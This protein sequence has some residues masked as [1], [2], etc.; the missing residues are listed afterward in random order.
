VK[1]FLY[2]LLGAGLLLIAAVAWTEHNFISPGPL[3]QPVTI[4]FAPGTHFTAIVNM[5]AQQRVITHPALFKILVF[6]RGDSARFK[7][8]EYLFP[9]HISPS[10]VATLMASGKT[11]IHHLT[12]PEGLMTS[13]ILNIVKHNDALDGEIT[14][15]LHEGDLLPET[16]NF[17]RG[18]K[19]NEILT[20]MHD[21]MQKT[22]SDAW[23]GR[24]DNL[25]FSD[26][27]QVLILASIVEK[28]TGLASERTRIAAVYINRL[29][30]GMLL[31]A[32]P[33]TAY[34]ITQGRH[35][36]DRLLTTKDLGIDS[37]YNTYR[38][39]GLPPAPIANP[40]KA[41][42]IATLHPDVSDE[43][44]FV[45]TGMGG[46]NFARTPE[47]HAQNV[48]KYREMENIKH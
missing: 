41:T 42:I 32:D 26:P 29:K 21:A 17:S 2:T 38:Y 33:T 25:P 4:V 12:I 48:K 22:L 30:R 20:R 45:A 16:Y 46:H 28:E 7:A 39:P 15:D 19:R 37:P 23:A 10:E 43:L 44:Y 3:E 34:A 24:A 35:K 36:L 47:E 27:R 13:E 1:A 5:L 6:A 14:L 9:A 31:Q 8:G 11:V 40:G 18:D